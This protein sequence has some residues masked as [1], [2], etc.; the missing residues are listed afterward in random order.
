MQGQRLDSPSGQPVLLPDCPQGQN[1]FQAE[2]LFFQL[3]PVVSNP[4]A[5]LHL[6]D[7]LPTDTEGF[8]KV[9]IPTPKSHLLQADQ[10]QLPQ[11]LLTGQVLQPY[12]LGGPP[13]NRIHFTDVF[14]LLGCP[15]LEGGRQG[16]KAGREDHILKRYCGMQAPQAPDRT[17]N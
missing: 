1:V 15:K 7:H 10:A 13:L 12:P 16:K 11:P 4:S 8:C 2:P 14:F 9:L 5:L 3:M 6:L 17:R